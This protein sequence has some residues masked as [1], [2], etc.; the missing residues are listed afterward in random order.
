MFVT[1]SMAQS[2]GKV[3]RVD[4]LTITSL[5]NKCVR[6]RGMSLPPRSMHSIRNALIQAS[7]QTLPMHAQ[8][9]RLF[10][11]HPDSGVLYIYQTCPIHDALLLFCKFSRSLESLETH[12]LERCGTKQNTY[13][14]FKH[15]TLVDRHPQQ[16][17]HSNI[18]HFLQHASKCFHTHACM[19]KCTPLHTLREGVGSG[20]PDSL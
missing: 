18:S 7:Q 19:H 10:V 3:F 9:L 16:S 14:R 8:L 5:C 2:A 6:L 13:S 15:S 17:H 1:Q 4:C 20:R 12:K 11:T